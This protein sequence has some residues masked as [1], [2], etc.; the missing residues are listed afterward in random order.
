MNAGYKPRLLALGPNYHVLVRSDECSL[1]IL[2]RKLTNFDW[3]FVLT[4]SWSSAFYDR[5]ECTIYG[6]CWTLKSPSNMTRLQGGVGRSS[7]AM[8][9]LDFACDPWT[10][11]H[12]ATVYLV[13][14]AFDVTVV[15]ANVEKCYTLIIGHG[16]FCRI[17][18]DEL[19]FLYCAM[20]FAL[21][22][23]VHWVRVSARRACWGSHHSRFLLVTPPTQVDGNQLTFFLFA[24]A[25]IGDATRLCCVYML[26]AICVDGRLRWLFDHA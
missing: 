9:W 17:L 1:V 18:L 8:L 19:L 7:A 13:T 16:G 25:N 10:N 5:G 4:R 12:V 3:I 15:T 14:F 26:R 24:N 2:R 11:A 20:L 22:S 21:T 6:V 23:S